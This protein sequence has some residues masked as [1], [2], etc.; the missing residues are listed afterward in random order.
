MT[1]DLIKPVPLICVHA[2][3]CVIFSHKC[4][5][6]DSCPVLHRFHPV[7][8]IVKEVRERFEGSL[9]RVYVSLDRL[10]VILSALI[11]CFHLSK[12]KISAAQ[13]NT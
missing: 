2:P 5:C 9:I 11:S 13:V 6:L 1:D 7:Q 3:I 4:F 12:A 10:G 8:A